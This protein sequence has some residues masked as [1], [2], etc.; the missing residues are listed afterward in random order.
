MIDTIREQLEAEH[1]DRVAREADRQSGERERDLDKH[2]AQARLRREVRDAFYKEKGYVEYENS[3]GET[4]WLLPEEH[5]RRVRSRRHRK[6]RKVSPTQKL[7][8]V[9]SK[10]W[11]IMV[12][13]GF[14]LLGL[15]L[16]KFVLG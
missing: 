9:G 13:A 15:A 7:F 6:R 16:G 1:A 2:R 10:P 4:V 8:E 12:A 5:E 14:L 3:R 11:W